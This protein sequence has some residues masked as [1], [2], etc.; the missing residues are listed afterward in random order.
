MLQS[1][2]YEKDFLNTIIFLLILLRSELFEL[3]VQIK[4]LNEL[5]FALCV[6]Q[7]FTAGEIFRIAE[8]AKGEREVEGY[9]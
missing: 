2:R 5:N 7:Y 4:N 9:D 8:M 6:L 1:L 3:L